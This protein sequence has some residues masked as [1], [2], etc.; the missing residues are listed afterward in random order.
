[1]LK[2]F[3]TVYYLITTM[4]LSPNRHKNQSVQIS[5][6][7]PISQHSSEET[8]HNTTNASMNWKIL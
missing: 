6:S 3:L 5:S 2:T 4:V 8:K 7:K 1:M